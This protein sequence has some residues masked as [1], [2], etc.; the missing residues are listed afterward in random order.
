MTEISDETRQEIGVLL[1]DRRFNTV[2]LQEIHQVG[3]ERCGENWMHIVSNEVYEV[4]YHYTK[5]VAPW[6]RQETGKR[7]AIVGRI[8]KGGGPVGAMGQFHDYEE[9]SPHIQIDDP[10]YVSDELRQ[11]GHEDSSEYCWWY[12]AQEGTNHL[13]R[14]KQ[15][16]S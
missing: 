5:R 8:V 2:D 11:P 4:V 14:E 12:P 15:P 13:L 3:R 7:R 6:D 16:G 9:E 1:A 10:V